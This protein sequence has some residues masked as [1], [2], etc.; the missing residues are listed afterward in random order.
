MQFLSKHPKES[1]GSF[2]P[3]NLVLPEN[4]TSATLGM[5]ICHT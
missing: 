3:D 1:T 4:D 5:L 2:Q